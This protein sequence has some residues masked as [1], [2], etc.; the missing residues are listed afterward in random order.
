M[1]MVSKNVKYNNRRITILCVRT[2]GVSIQKYYINT[3]L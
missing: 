1:M 3:Q 2:D